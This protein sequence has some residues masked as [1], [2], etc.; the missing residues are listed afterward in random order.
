[1]SAASEAARL[2]IIVADFINTDTAGKINILGGGV[3]LIGF[4][5]LQGIT[6]R[7][8]VYAHADFPASVLPA[9]VSVELALMI[10]E[11]VVVT[12][13]GPI[14][15]QA[16]RVAQ[17]PTVDRANLPIPVHLRDHVGGS[18]NVIL[19]FG[20]GLPLQPNTNYEFRFQIDGD[21]DNELRYPLSIVGPPA[22]A[23]V[24]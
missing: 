4:D 11:E 24:G 22:S 20:N 1:M 10:G 3:A 9:D 5:P 12:A 17:T 8:A 23:V 2:T 13:G 14:G 7:F 15:P 16:I 19:D 21:A 18:T 6:N